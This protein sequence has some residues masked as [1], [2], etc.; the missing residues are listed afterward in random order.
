MAV[1]DTLKN[2]FEELA[3][4][5]RYADASYRRGYRDGLTRAMEVLSAQLQQAE[6]ADEEAS[7]KGLP[8]QLKA[9][10]GSVPGRILDVLE[11]CD[12]ATYQE[13]VEALKHRGTPTPMPSVRSAMRRLLEGNRVRNDSRRWFVV[14]GSFQSTEPRSEEAQTSSAG[15]LGPGIEGHRPDTKHELTELRR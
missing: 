13:I 7:V 2:I 14:S 3:A 10:R 4:L 9:R 8:R 5:K 6:N 12:G 11:H 1:D 15:G